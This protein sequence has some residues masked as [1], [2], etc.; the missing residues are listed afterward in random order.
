MK[1][2]IA[3]LSTYFER[4]MEFNDFYDRI[5]IERDY[6]EVPVYKMKLRSEIVECYPQL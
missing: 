4:I 6:K 5:M 2:R 3:D 1:E